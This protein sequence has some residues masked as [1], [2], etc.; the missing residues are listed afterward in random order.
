MTFAGSRLALGMMANGNAQ[1]I[2]FDA[3]GGFGTIG[4]GTMEKVDTTAYNT[5]KITGD[6]AFGVAGL[7]NLNNRAAMA[8]PFTSNG[9]GALPTAAVDLHPHAVYAAP[10]STP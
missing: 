6:Y 7:D 8:G 10:T 2:K 9:A 3:G 4:S 1:F 5:A